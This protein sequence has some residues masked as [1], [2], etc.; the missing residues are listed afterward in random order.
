MSRIKIM[1]DS[2]DLSKPKH[3]PKSQELVDTVP[4]F[5]PPGGKTPLPLEK[6]YNRSGKKQ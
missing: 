6:S 5:R 1:G 3:V 2:S 4:R